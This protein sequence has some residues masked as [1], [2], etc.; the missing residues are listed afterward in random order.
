VLEWDKQ[1]QYE[2]HAQLIFRLKDQHG[3]AVEQFDVRL[4]SASQ[5]HDSP[6]LE[7]MIEDHHGNKK[8]KGTI[9]FYLRTQ[10]FDRKRKVWRE[11]LSDVAGVSVEITGYEPDS[12]DIS[13]VPMNIQLDRAQINALLQ[14]FRTTIIDITLVRLP[15]DRVFTVE[16][17]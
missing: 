16:R 7:R 11:L 5:N 13:Y 2:G 15:S 17:G 8:D 14:S 9:T 1:Q 3:N 6:K 4:N 10:S 12:G